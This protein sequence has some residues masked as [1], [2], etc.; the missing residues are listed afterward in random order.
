M[1][2]GC[3]I[4]L[5]TIL[6]L[7]V[8]L[9]AR[10]LYI[11]QSQR[12]RAKRKQ[13]LIQFRVRQARSMKS[14]DS[15]GEQFKEAL[16]DDHCLFQDAA[17]MRKRSTR[18][19]F[20]FRDTASVVSKLTNLES[21]RWGS[22]GRTFEE[23]D[24]TTELM[25]AEVFLPA[26]LQPTPGL[27]LPSISQYLTE[28]QAQPVESMDAW[29]A[30][31]YGTTT[32]TS[33]SHLVVILSTEAAALGIWRDGELIKHKCITAYTVR[34]KQ[35][36]SQISHMR[37]KSKSGRGSAGGALRARESRR[38]F[39]STCAKLVEWS[40]EIHECDVIFGSGTVRVWNELFAAGGDILPCPRCDPRWRRVGKSVSRPRLKELERVYGLLSHGS[41]EFH[42]PETTNISQGADAL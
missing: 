6:N 2:L 4:R 38:L 8:H 29:F 31:V 10:Q 7:H 17:D 5:I 13:P 28:L 20:S 23:F 35:G 1:L 30:D 15:E 11:S 33:V 22:D 37:R 32:S 14:T 3:E 19:T 42:V 34:Q 27:P 12:L 25:L 39:E 18:K 41:I 21:L 9:R 40:K 36:K 16:V 26:V 24:P